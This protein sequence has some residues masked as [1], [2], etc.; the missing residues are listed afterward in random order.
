M[1]ERLADLLRSARSAVALTGAGV[2]APSGIPDFRSVSTGLWR[3]IDPME[4]GHVRAFERDP[5]RFWRFFGDRLGLVAG[6]RPSGAHCALAELERRG[7]LDLLITQ[8]VDRLHRAAG[9]RNVVEVHGS[10]DTSS[11]P[12]CGGRYRLA[13]VRRRLAVDGV[14]PRCDCGTVLKPDVILFGE[15]LQPEPMRL[16]CEAAA[17]ADLL[18]C[19]GSSLEV[20]P[21]A[22]LPGVTRRA[23]GQVAIVTRG[24]TRQDR[25]AAVK[26]S[27]DIEAEMEALLAAL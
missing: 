14:A 26:L 1:T 10:I 4:V 7:M 16:A 8:N 5:V 19:I 17:R 12:A 23:G 24:P 9:N 22:Q 18:L 11:C 21:V 2:S 15:H 13:D 27:G 25:W 3:G 6:A 20:H